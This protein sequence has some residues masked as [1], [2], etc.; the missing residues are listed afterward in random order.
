MDANIYYFT[1]LYLDRKNELN[2]KKCKN[3]I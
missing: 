2:Q 1:K 3:L